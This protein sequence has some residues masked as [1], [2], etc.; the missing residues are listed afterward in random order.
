MLS[1]LAALISDSQIQN[2]ST[3]MLQNIPG[4]PPI[5]QTIHLLGIAAIMASVLMMDLR[6]LGLAVPS[7]SIDEMAV[8]LK[9]WAV[10]GVAAIAL[11]GM[12]FVLAR[13]N[14][15]F[16]NPVFQIKFALLPLALLTSYLIFQR[17]LRS[18]GYWEH[19]SRR[20]LLA[21]LLALISLLL[22]LTVAMAGRWIAYSEYLFWNE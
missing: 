2:A 17:T 12:W 9:V 5:L 18:P 8:R 22:W 3:W 19:S 1:N 4:L 16:F 14:R 21:K 20:I 10:G 7:Q 11:S 6:I 15:Y 13:P